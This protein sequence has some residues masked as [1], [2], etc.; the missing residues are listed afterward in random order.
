MAKRSAQRRELPGLA[1]AEPLETPLHQSMVEWLRIMVPPPPEGPV[2]FHPYNSAELAGSKV[3]RIK[4]WQ[5]ALSMGALP[6]IHDLVF[7]WVGET[8][9]P[10]VVEVKRRH[11]TFSDAQTKVALQLRSVGINVH[12]ARSIEDLV[13]ALR[14]EGVP[15]KGRTHGKS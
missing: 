12:V 8:R 9:K 2:W 7:L 6:G 1:T 10:F 5:H 14:H 13:D 4:Q 15:L 11:E 3:E